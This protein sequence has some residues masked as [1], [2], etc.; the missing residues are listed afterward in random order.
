MEYTG[1]SNGTGRAEKG[2]GRKTR[3][4]QRKMAKEVEF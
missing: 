2:A 3:E 4:L 1:L